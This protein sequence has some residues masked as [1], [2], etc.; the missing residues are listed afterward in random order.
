MAQGHATDAGGKTPGSGKKLE[1][2]PREFLKIIAVWSLVPSY[3]LAGGF[4]GYLADRW[5]NTYPYL[6][7]LGLLLALVVAVRDMLRLRTQM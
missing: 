6:T 3:M 4:L 7:A 5:L 2:I 1:L